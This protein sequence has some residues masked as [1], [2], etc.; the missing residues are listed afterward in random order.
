MIDRKYVIAIDLILVVGTLFVV[1]GF[2][3]Y[4]RPL[5][6]S[7]IDDYN[8][9]STSVLF[10]FER[11]NLIV[12]DDNIGFTSPQEYYV[13]NDLVI[14]L[15]PGEYYWKVSGIGESDI[16][17]L[18]IESEISLRLREDGEN[19]SVVNSGNTP[20][21]VEVYED[22]ELVDNLHLETDSVE[23]AKGDGFV[24]RENA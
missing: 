22:G 18:T 23:S 21:N 16:R 15:K 6:I 11:A 24:G 4:A 19:Y 1:A 17:K 13:K 14:T 20:L 7:P 12:I 10:S 2:V 9:T 5:I 8:T 3:G